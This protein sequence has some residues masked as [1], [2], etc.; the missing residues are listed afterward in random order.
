MPVGTAKKPEQKNWLRESFGPRLKAIREANKLAQDGVAQLLGNR[1]TQYEVSKWECGHTSPDPYR[2]ALL[3]SVYPEVDFRY[4][5]DL[6]RQ[7]EKWSKGKP[8]L[9]PECNGKPHVKKRWMDHY[10]RFRGRG[11]K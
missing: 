5:F 11:F 2:L 4:L 6:K 7:E 8:C 1:I 3:L 9:L 10:R